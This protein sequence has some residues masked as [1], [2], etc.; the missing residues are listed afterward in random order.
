[1]CEPSKVDD[2]WIT[3]GCHIDI[4]GVE[5]AVYPDHLGGVGFR[6][7]FSSTSAK[8]AHQAIK[9]AKKRCLPDPAVRER[10]IRR[11]QMA[12]VYMLNY[13]SDSVANGRM[14]EFK[15]LQI[16]IKRCGS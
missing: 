7:V 9:I 5:L 2:D 6:P 11:L 12:T 16:A 3:K 1:M 8:A 15:F 14:L 13:P 10:W 4:N